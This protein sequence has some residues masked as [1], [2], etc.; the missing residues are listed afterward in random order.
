MEINRIESIFEK[1]KLLQA[2]KHSLEKTITKNNKQ[3]IYKK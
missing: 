2:K 1:K 3:Y